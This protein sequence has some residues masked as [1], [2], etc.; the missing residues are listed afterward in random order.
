MNHQRLN[1]NIK[2]WK[3]SLKLNKYKI[4]I[5]NNNQIKKFKNF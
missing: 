3:I 4:Q 2:F 1:K 5:Y